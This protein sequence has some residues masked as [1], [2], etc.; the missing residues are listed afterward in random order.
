MRKFA[1]IISVLFLLTACDCIYNVRGVVVDAST[2][3][4]IK[5][6]IITKKHK[7]PVISDDSGS[8]KYDG[9]SGSCNKVSVIVEKEG[10]TPVKHTIH[11]FTSDTIYLEPKINY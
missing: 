4:P 3:Q 7:E 2:K 5:D 8:F 10:Y 1:I 11:N 9:V 6:A